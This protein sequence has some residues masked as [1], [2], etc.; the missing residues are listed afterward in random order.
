MLS[1]CCSSGKIFL[2]E[3]SEQD[4]FHQ[5]IHTRTLKWGW[6]THPFTP[7][8]PF[9]PPLLRP[10]PPNA[11]IYSH[12]H[13]IPHHFLLPSYP[14]MT[15]DIYQTRSIIYISLRWL[16]DHSQILQNIP[17]YN[18]TVCVCMCVGLRIRWYPPCAF[19]L[20]M[21]T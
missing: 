18:F 8:L 11:R 19:Q 2:W 3:I 1:C 9:P 5:R 6:A 21:L 7:A 16:C 15:I 20:M 12:S 4:I 14:L 13:R 10:P 17:H